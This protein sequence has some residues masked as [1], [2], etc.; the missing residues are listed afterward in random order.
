VREAVLVFITI[1]LALPCLAIPIAWPIRIALAVIIGLCGAG[2]TFGRIPP[3][4][5]RVE[6]VLYNFVKFAGRSRVQQR[7][8]GKTT[9]DP[10][11]RPFGATSEQQ[12]RPKPVVQNIDAPSY[13]T[14]ADKTRR[15]TFD[16]TPSYFAGVVSIAFLAMVIAWALM[17]GVNELLSSLGSF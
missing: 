8:A 1:V 11:S 9:D 3:T 13:P 15:L 4:G 2:V 17:G 12:P 14:E 16:L 5:E 7:G 10:E 6:E